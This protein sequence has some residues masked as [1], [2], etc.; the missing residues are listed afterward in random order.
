MCVVGVI[1]SHRPRNLVCSSCCCIRGA[2]CLRVGFPVSN[3]C[4]HHGINEDY[5]NWWGIPVVHSFQQI[6]RSLRN[7]FEEDP[8]TEPAA[9]LVS[10]ADWP[11]CAAD[12]SIMIPGCIS[13]RQCKSQWFEVFRSVF[14]GLLA[15][16][17]SQVGHE[18]SSEMW[19]RYWFDSW[20]DFRTRN[21]QS[22][23]EFVE[24]WCNPKTS[25][26]PIYSGY[27]WLLLDG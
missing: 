25:G 26:F 20:A 3:V 6:S 19:L 18:L 16:G 9:S 24:K 17:H 1:K 27:I 10:H 11:S 2:V 8:V 12:Y 21:L 4:S 5:W 23:C 15:A 22:W 7:N 13:C 14:Q